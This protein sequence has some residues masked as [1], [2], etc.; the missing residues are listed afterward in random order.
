[1]KPVDHSQVVPD[2]KPVDQILHGKDHV[3][4]QRVVP[5]VIPVD[6]PLEGW[7]NLQI[8]FVI[9]FLSGGVSGGHFVHQVDADTVPRVG[10]QNPKHDITQLLYKGVTSG[11]FVPEVNADQIPVVGFRDHDNDVT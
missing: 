8:A 11:S 5:G 3:Y 7:N 4:D 9:G 1:M 10:F 6:R 2:M